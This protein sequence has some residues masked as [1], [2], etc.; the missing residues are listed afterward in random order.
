M[1][2]LEDGSYTPLGPEAT[3]R[4]R[5]P[6]RRRCGGKRLIQ[7]AAGAEVEGGRKATAAAA[8]A[9]LPPSSGSRA[10]PLQSL[11]NVSQLKVSATCRQINSS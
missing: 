4:G 11:C 6:I 7:K 1:G 10:V 9:L 2:L 8:A 5:K 3:K